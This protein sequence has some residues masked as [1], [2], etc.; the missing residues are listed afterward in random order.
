MRPVDKIL[1]RLERVRATSGGWSACCPAH[2]DRNP[3]LSIAEGD[4]GRVLVHCFGGCSAL[5]VVQSIGLS[6]SDLFPERIKSTMT[7]EQR[8]AL[9]E[10]WRQSNIAAAVNV[11]DRE[12]M[13]VLIAA[14]ELLGWPVFAPD[15]YQRLQSALQAIGDARAVING[16]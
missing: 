1:D 14:R 12:S 15:D 2:D 6:L 4:D 5:D 11:L 8:A 16:H 7:R 9:R 13:V 3:S 10:R